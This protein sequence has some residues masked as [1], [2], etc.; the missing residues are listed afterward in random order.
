[1]QFLHIYVLPL[2]SLCFCLRLSLLLNTALSFGTEQLTCTQFFLDS[3]ADRSY[4]CLRR[5]GTLF[6]WP[7]GHAILLEDPRYIR[8]G[9]LPCRI[10]IVCRARFAHRQIIRSRSDSIRILQLFCPL[11][12]VWLQLNSA[13]LS[14]LSVSWRADLINTVSQTTIAVALA[15]LKFFQ[16]R[17]RSDQCHVFFTSVVP[18]SR[19]QLQLSMFLPFSPF[20]RHCKYGQ[21]HPLKISGTLLN[22]TWCGAELS[23]LARP[24]CNFLYQ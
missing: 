23:T 17:G 24:R 11:L 7:R 5:S 10:L 13:A 14:G 8:P 22:G 3:A 16:C 21:P 9:L 2:A 15:L 4:C 6:L 1:V 19:R 12:G 20:P 18:H